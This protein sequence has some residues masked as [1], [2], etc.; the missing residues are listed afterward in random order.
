M[1]PYDLKNLP[2]GVYQVKIETDQEEV[3]YK[4]ETKDQP[5]SIS[6][7]PLMASAKIMDKNTVNLA[8]FGLQEPGVYVEVYSS[9]S[10]EII[11]TDHVDQAEGFRKDYSFSQLNVSEIY[12]KVS[13]AQGRTKTLNF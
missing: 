4:V 8:V 9:E 11:Y 2:A 13:D 12:L 6:A 7:L 10:G 5:T 1:V 3:S